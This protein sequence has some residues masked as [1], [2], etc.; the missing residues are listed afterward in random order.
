MDPTNS[1]A[2]LVDAYHSTSVAILRMTAATIPMNLNAEISHAAHHNLHVQMV[3]AFQI[4]G[5]AI[6]KTIVV[7]A[8]MK[9]TSVLRKLA[10]ISNSHVPERVTVYL[11]VGYATAMMI[12]LINKTKK[13]ALR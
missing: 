3:V 13:I 4:C 12:A 5:N 1:N 8:P 11:R 6:V 2:N 10:L 7:M 9:V